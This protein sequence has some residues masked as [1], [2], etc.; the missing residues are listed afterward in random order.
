[1]KKVFDPKLQEVVIIDETKEK[2]WMSKYW[3]N[4]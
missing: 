3:H 2:D 4:S 1:M